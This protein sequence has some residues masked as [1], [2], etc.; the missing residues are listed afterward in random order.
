M[1]VLP[2]SSAVLPA[3]VRRRDHPHRT[4]PRAAPM[5]MVVGGRAGLL[6]RIGAEVYAV[7]AV[8]GDLSV[9]A[10]RSLAWLALGPCRGTLFPSFYSVGVRSVPVV[11]I[12]GTFVGMVLA[13]QSYATLHQLGLETRL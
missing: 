12:T 9:F 8:V 1:I 4:E 7:V 2:P 13:V 3:D 10:G 5:S 6:D 11:A